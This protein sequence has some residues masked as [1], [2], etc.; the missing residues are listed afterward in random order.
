MDH[1]ASQEVGIEKPTA[2][3]LRKSAPKNG[4]VSFVGGKTDKTSM[5]LLTAK[6][7]SPRSYRACYSLP[8]DY[9][10][11]A[12]SYAERGTA[13]AKAIGL[14][15]PATMAARSRKGRQVAETDF[16]RSVLRS[17]HGWQGVPV[18]RRVKAKL[19]TALRVSCCY[20]RSF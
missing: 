1:Q 8:V 18:F 9:P 16:C 14:G 10:M 7:L 4:L 12:P 2:A 17:A 5:R 13:I 11:V 15:R 6:G 19:G 20:L 3:R